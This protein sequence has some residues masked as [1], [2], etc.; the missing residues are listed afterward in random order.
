M[1]LW[2]IGKILRKGAHYCILH[3]THNAMTPRIVEY[4]NAYVTVLLS[5]YN[6]ESE[7]SHDTDKLRY[8]Y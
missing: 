5:N 7:V 1:F 6:A 8:A 2:I 4:L 3:M